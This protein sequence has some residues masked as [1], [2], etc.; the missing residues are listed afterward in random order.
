MTTKITTSIALFLSCFCFA[1]P[2]L[3]AQ[4]GTGYGLKKISATEYTAESLA[5]MLGH[6]QQIAIFNDSFTRAIIELPVMVHIIRKDDASGSV[7]V[8]ECQAA[9]KQLNEKFLPIYLR[10]L[11]LP[12]YNYINSSYFYAFDKSKEE[13]LCAK[14]DVPNVINLYIIGTLKIDKN[15]Y[16]G[17]TYP[18]TNRPKDRI[19]VTYKT[20]M[21]KVTLPRQ[22]GHYLSLYP[23]HGTHATERGNELADGM[24]CKTEGDELCDTP[25]DPRLDGRM[26]DGRCTYIGNMQDGNNRFYRPMIENYMS[27]N[28]RISCLTTF[29]R[30]QY[31]RML[32]A[33]LNIRNYLAFPRNGMS[34]KQ[35][36]KLEESY[37]ISA[38]VDLLFDGM[39]PSVTLERNLYIVNKKQQAGNSFKINISNHRKC[40]IYVLEGDQERGVQLLYPNKGDKLF[41]DDKTTRFS[42]PADD[43][44]FTVD[45]KGKGSNYITILYSKNQLNIQDVLTKI[46]SVEDSKLNIL[47]RIYFVLGEDIVPINDL[48]YDTKGLIKVSGITTERTLVPIFIEYRQD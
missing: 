42:L 41:F 3:S 17:Y 22:M 40:Y 39:T 29:T 5:F 13:E 12:D 33:A 6:R 28:P 9:L 26:V 10:F 46:N 32:Y 7:S 18:P 30:Q 23:T 1:L 14:Y 16:N 31:G 4:G 45:S 34:A 48:S 47:Q 8:A 27:D 38:D 11:S 37:G 43:Q 25:A 36:K 19:F 20:L 2:S 35:R 44:S 15:N 21:D 24:N